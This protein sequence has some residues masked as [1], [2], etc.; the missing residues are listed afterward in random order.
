MAETRGVTRRDL[1]RMAAAG[2]VTTAVGLNLGEG[3][4]RAAG[5]ADVVGPPPTTPQAALQELRD[6][7]AR[8]LAH[9][10]G[11]FNEDLRLINS[12]ATES[13]I[14]FAAIL[15]CADARVSPEIIYDQAMG[16]L[17]VTR[18][19]GNIATPEIIASLEFSL[20]VLR[21]VRLIVVLGH[22]SCGAVDNAIA[23]TAAP[24]QISVLYAALRA[25]V[26]LGGTS[27]NDEKTRLNARIQAIILR[28]SSPVIAPLVQQGAL[29]VVAAYYDIATGVVT[30]L[31]LPPVSGPPGP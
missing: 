16:D 28:D 22:R 26:N 3:G 5:A 17:F 11:S 10:P 25:A 24:G 15:S 14:P 1:F 2:G 21:T 7:N 18:V 30:E 23:R 31:P 4:P 27:S 19:A 29:F 12:G 20:A 9:V 6:G 8:F 13:H